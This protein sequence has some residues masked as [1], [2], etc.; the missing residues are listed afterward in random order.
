MILFF[1]P[2]VPPLSLAG[3]AKD[4]KKKLTRQRKQYNKIH[5][6]H[7]PEHRH[8][9]DGK[10]RAEKT[11]GNG[12]RGR[13]PELELRQSANERAKLLVLLDGQTTLAVL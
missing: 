8:I 13:M 7:R 10:P 6:Q 2:F 1:P 12:S 5:H 3:P 11:D 9:K 4:D